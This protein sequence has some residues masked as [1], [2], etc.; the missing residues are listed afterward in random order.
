MLNFAV[1]SE[2]NGVWLHQIYTSR[3]EAKVAMDTLD[4]LLNHDWC[5]FLD[6]IG[7][8]PCFD[9]HVSLFTFLA[10]AVN[11]NRRRITNSRYG[12]RYFLNFT[13]GQRSSTLLNHILGAGYDE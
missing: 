9:K 10:G 8:H 7:V 3:P 5:I 4:N 1:I 12:L 2:G 13:R 6:L 11:T